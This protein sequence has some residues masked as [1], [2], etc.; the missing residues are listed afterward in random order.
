MLE[1]RYILAL[2]GQRTESVHEFTPAGLAPGCTC[3]RYS[4]GSVHI[5]GPAAIFEIREIVTS[6]N[7]HRFGARGR[8]TVEG[9]EAKEGWVPESGEP[10]PYVR[11]RSPNAAASPILEEETINGHHYQRGVYTCDRNG[12]NI[13]RDMA[14]YHPCPTMEDV[15]F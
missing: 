6:E 10:C 7:G 4:D 3:F 1:P 11:R 5:H 14:P 13:V 9:C 8:C 12:C 15:P 2:M